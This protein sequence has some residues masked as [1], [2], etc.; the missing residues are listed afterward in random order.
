MENR[1]G[2]IVDAMATQ[3]D[4]YAERD[5]GLLLLDAQRR[6]GRLAARWSCGA[7]RAYDQPDFVGTVRG[8][9][10]AAHVSQ[11]LRRAEDRRLDAE[12]E[13]PRPAER[14]VALRLR[15]RGVQPGAVQNAAGPAGVTA[16]ETDTGPARAG[17]IA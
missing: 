10:G 4:G 17:G 11:N 5:A 1:H 2:L 6:R 12:G 9:G 15:E 14:R 13:A 7:D 3:A 8:M 16:I